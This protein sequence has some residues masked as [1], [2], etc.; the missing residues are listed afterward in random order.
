MLVERADRLASLTSNVRRT[1]FFPLLSECKIP[2]GLFV[3]LEASIVHY[4]HVCLSEF[5]ERKV[6]Y[7]SCNILEEYEA[8]IVQLPN[9]TPNG[10]VLPKKNSFLLYNQIHRC[11]ARILSYCRMDDQIT[12]V[13]HPVN[14]RVVNGTPN[15]MIDSRPRASSKWHTDVWAGELPQSIVVFL[16]VF[17]DMEENG[18]E[19]AEPNDAFYPQYVCSLPDY[20]DGAGVVGRPYDFRM[21][22]GSIYF[23]DSYLLHRTQ[24]KAAGLRLSVDFRLLP[25]KLLDSDLKLKTPR[26]A[27]YLPRAD[28]ATCGESWLLHTNANA[29]EF[30][31]HETINKSSNMYA[32]NFDRIDL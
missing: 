29:S 21:R 16:P 20:D 15:P 19:F 8:D 1:Q 13:H 11:V 30:P 7:P 18:V 10:L 5:F 14:I 32:A 27:D 23:M 31:F 26:E 28:W 17:G 6:F 12:A 22:T 4:L 25:K 24:K 2:R 9:I 3:S